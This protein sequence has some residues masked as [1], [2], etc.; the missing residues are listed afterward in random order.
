MKV[1]KEEINDQVDFLAIRVEDNNTVE[2]PS[3]QNSCERKNRKR[4]FNLEELVDNCTSELQHENKKLSR[5]SKSKSPLISVPASKPQ[6]QSTKP[7][8][9][10]NKD[11]ER[12]T[13]GR[14][15]RGGVQEDESPVYSGEMMSGDE[16]HWRTARLPLVAADTGADKVT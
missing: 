3:V 15:P 7:A 6:Q 9:V 10:Q 14:R 12:R 8:W 11:I 1:M 13:Y 4:E 5:K 2:S 16:D